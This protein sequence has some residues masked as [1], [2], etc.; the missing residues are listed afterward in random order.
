MVVMTA[1]D[2]RLAGRVMEAMRLRDAQVGYVEALQAEAAAS[3]PGRPAALA[4]AEAK[5]L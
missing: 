4:E 1:E 5:S 2:M 3:P